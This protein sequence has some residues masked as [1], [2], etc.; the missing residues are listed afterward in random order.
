M[1]I[2]HKHAEVMSCMITVHKH[3]HNRGLGGEKGKMYG[4]AV[5]YYSLL[6]YPS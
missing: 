3:I 4:S 2:N 6:L 5:S 1:A